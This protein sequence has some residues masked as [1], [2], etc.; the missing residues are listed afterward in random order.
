MGIDQEK[1]HKRRHRSRSRS[2]S[3]SKEKY[4]EHKKVLYCNFFQILYILNSPLFRKG[5]G[6]DPDLLTERKEG[7]EKKKTEVEAGAEVAE[8]MMIVRDQKLMIELIQ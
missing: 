3:R 6:T 7:I 8:E 1:K 5:K 4:R 2:R